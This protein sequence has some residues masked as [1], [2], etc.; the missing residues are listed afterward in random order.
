[1]NRLAVLL[2]R[3]SIKDGETARVVME[4]GRIAVVPNHQGESEEESSGDEMEIDDV[5]DA[6]GDD[7]AI[8]LYD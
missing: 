7:G 4:D 6:L 8:E 1:L 2:L 3:G 5:T